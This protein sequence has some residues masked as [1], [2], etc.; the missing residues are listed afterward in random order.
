MSDKY[1]VES[2]NVSPNSKQTDNIILDEFVSMDIPKGVTVNPDS[3]SKD[4]MDGIDSRRYTKAL[5]NNSKT[6]TDNVND[7]DNLN[8]KTDDKPKNNGIENLRPFNTLTEEE[9]RELAKKGGKA[10]GESRKQRKT[11]KENLKLLLECEFSPEQVKDITG[12]FY[13]LT[14]GDNSVQQA[15]MVQTLMQAMTGDT[16]AIA[17]VRDTIGEKPVEE[18][19]ITADIMTDA[20]R[21]VLANVIKRTSKDSTE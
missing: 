20:D 13:N 4:N 3:D 15:L 5:I 10:S 9:H 8:T 1:N 21:K 6:T 11:M 17:F 7:N 14:G 12:D 2:M 18:S 19:V 16:K